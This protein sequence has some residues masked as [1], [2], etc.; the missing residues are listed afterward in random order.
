MFIN[1]F[2]EIIVGS[3]ES[4]AYDSGLNAV[5]HVTGDIPF[6]YSFVQPYIIISIIGFFFLTLLFLRL[7]VWKTVDSLIIKSWILSLFVSALITTLAY[8]FFESYFTVKVFIHNVLT[9][10]LMSKVYS[11]HSVISITNLLIMLS[12]ALFLCYISIFYWGFY[13]FKKGSL[14]NFMTDLVMFVDKAKS[15]FNL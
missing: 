4:I 1:Y 15:K 7:L 5:V 11:C 12:V 9:A 10:G 2:Y 8:V 3:A 13:Q 6:N 14:T